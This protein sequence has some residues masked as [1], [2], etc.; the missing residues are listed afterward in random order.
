MGNEHAG[1]DPERHGHRHDRGV[2]GALR[3]LRWLPELWRSAIN[4]AVVDLAAPQAG[5]RAVDIGA[6][7]GAAAIRAA[8]SGADVVAVEPTPF[9]R[10]LLSARRTL[11]RR[12]SRIEVVDGAAERI[13]VDDR[14]VDVI[15][16]VNTMHH[17]VDPERAAAEIARVLRPGGRALLVDED[18]DHPS[19]PEH[20]RFGSHD[21]AHHPFEPVEGEQM[22]RLL[23]AAGLVDVV[24]AERRIAGRPVVAVS[25]RGRDDRSD[26][27][28]ASP[29]GAT[30]VSC[31]LNAADAA[32][33]L[34][35]SDAVAA[36]WNE[37]SVLDGYRVGGLAA[38]LARSVHTVRAYLGAEP[39][40]AGSTPLAASEYFAEALGDH[41]PV[42]S[43]FHAEVR[44]RGE[45]A[46]AGGPAAVADGMRSAV[47]ELRAAEL[48]P[49][50]LVAV[51]GGLPMRL[52]D[53]LETR[54]VELAVHSVDLAESVHVEAPSFT[55]ETWSA[56]ARVAV[57][58]GVRRT[59]ARTVALAVTRPERHGPMS[60]FG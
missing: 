1:H 55:E 41:D 45:D 6:G 24:A 39:P 21:A 44:R 57:E 19:H 46:A 18:F 48:D 27:D 22:G 13:P 37:P 3:Y 10:A 20:A 54:L 59:S 26:P 31:F 30:M 49:D 43:E 25:A 2:A 14:S 7:L 60:A 29:D 4:D 35:G 50:R 47:G 9:L 56:V 16:A 58:A 17:W 11:G 38:H 33:G 51:L 42:A 40:P 28:V 12:R 32:V 53:Y 5:E 52:G 8:G 23:R 15:W 36:R 34:V